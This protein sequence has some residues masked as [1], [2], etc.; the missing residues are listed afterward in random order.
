MRF[1]LLFLPTLPVIGFGTW[2]WVKDKMGKSNRPVKSISAIPARLLT[3]DDLMAHVLYIIDTYGPAVEKT[4]PAKAKELFF[5]LMQNATAL[6]ER[7]SSGRIPTSS[8]SDIKALMTNYLVSTNEFFLRQERSDR[9]KALI[10][11]YSQ[12]NRRL[13]E[14]NTALMESDHHEAGATNFYWNDKIIYHPPV[15]DDKE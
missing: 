4:F 8:A 7:Y 15:V 5:I 9:E 13:D 3:G 1:L 10:V 11:G 6:G 2:V 12:M 14:I